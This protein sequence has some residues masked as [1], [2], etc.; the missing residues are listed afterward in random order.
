[1]DVYFSC[2]TVVV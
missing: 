1:M 2:V